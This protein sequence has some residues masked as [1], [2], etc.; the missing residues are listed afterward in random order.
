MR[1]LL[2]AVVLCS[3]EPI[4]SGPKYGDLAISL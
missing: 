2:L 3:L 1:D 4:Q